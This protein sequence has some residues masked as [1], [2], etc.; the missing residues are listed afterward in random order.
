MG[1][2]S[3]A[4]EKE[5]AKTRPPNTIATAWENRTLWL[6]VRAAV[7]QSATLTSACFP[8][9]TRA[10][11]RNLLLLTVMHL[12]V[13]GDLTGCRT[14]NGEKLSNRPAAKQAGQAIK[15]AVA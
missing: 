5:A 12:R 7:A 14:G 9:A 6:R 1:A 10:S 13:Q 15:S 11:S 4:G 2:R 8:L 3:F